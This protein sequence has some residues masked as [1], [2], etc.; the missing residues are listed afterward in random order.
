MH[1]PKRENRERLLISCP[2]QPGIVAEVS[3]FLYDHGANIVQSDQYSTDPSGG[4]FFMRIEFDQ[5]EAGR[6]GR[7][8]KEFAGIAERFQM[9]WR[10]SS[11]RRRKRMA[12]FVSKFDH[13]LLELLWRWQAGDI[14]AEI[15]LVISNHPDLRETVEALHIPFHHIPVSKGNKEE[16]ENKQLALLRESDVDFVVLAR[17]MQILSP[18]FIAN[19][20]D[21]VINIHHSFLPAFVGARPYERAFERGVKIIGATSHYVTDDL[22]EG[23]IIEQGVQEVSHKHNVE[24]LKRIG[25]TI[26]RDVLA[27]AVSLHVADRV[28]VHGNKTIVF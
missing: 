15:P 20:P 19:Y 26:E 5:L 2:D 9:E 23:P 7:L 11:V 18:E 8:Q 6:T 24:E 28:I 14:D 27:R 25:R 17:Y 10:F 4:T 12:I 1:H 22:D 21:N 3:R 16:A 13:C